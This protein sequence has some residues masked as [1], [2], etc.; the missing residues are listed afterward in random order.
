MKKVGFK[1]S[2]VA[3]LVLLSSKGYALPY[4]TQHLE[5]I[6]VT[7][8]LKT[9][10]KKQM[11][12][13]N[14]ANYK[15]NLSD[16]SSMLPYQK[17]K[18]D[19]SA[20]PNNDLE[21]LIN[22]T[23]GLDTIGAPKPITQN[24]QVNGLDVSTGRSIFAINGVSQASFLNTSGHGNS[25]ILN[26]P[27]PFLLHSMSV[28]QSGSNLSF[29]SGDMGGVIDTETLTAKSL[30][31]NKEV[32][33]KLYLGFDFNND[34]FT[35]GIATGIQNDQF[36]FLIAGIG[37]QNN[38]Y[39]DGN[40][41]MVKDSEAHQFQGL[42]NFNWDINDYQ[43]LNLSYLNINNDTNSKI[44]PNDEHDYAPTILKL[45]TQQ[46]N[47]K[48]NLNPDNQYVNLKLNLF[49]LK[50]RLNQQTPSYSLIP[51]FPTIPAVNDK[52]TGTK[53]GFKIQN[54]TNLYKQNITYGLDYQYT[55][56]NTNSPRS[57]KT[58]KSNQNQFGIFIKDQIHLTKIW[59]ITPG[60][61]FDDYT[62]KGFDIP[63]EQNIKS[64]QTDKDSK[65]S[66]SISTKLQLTDSLS[67]YLA[68]TEGFRAP[69]F[70]EQFAYGSHAGGIPAIFAPNFSLKPEESANKEFGFDYKKVL[71]NDDLLTAHISIFQNDI[72]NFINSQTIGHT[73]PEPFIPFEIDQYQN[74]DKVRIKGVNINTSYKNEYFIFYTSYTYNR[75][76]NTDNG[77]LI[78]NMPLSKGYS[79][80]S[81]PVKSMDTTFIFSSNYAARQTYSTESNDG[82]IKTQVN[83]GYA[84]YNANVSYQPHSIKDLTL[85]AGINNITNKAYRT[86][87][88]SDFF[89][90]GRNV[91][92]SMNY[93]F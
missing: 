75:G 38:N 90:M 50:N 56:Y 67:T 58:P 9:K 91:F 51:G 27:S 73:P 8:Q 39:K 37:N 3:I 28:Y 31:K 42:I 70:F 60:L 17:Y 20:T 65:L 47:L 41:Q 55:K 10:Q 21:N 86:N 52:N 22:L 7:G 29:G 72:H 71:P 77:Q 45:N 2:S 62:N 89:E 18:I 6:E 30:L 82:S 44:F 68:Y 53:Q 84:I 69:N 59:S 16:S 26:T 14:F 43:S 49:Y 85:N 93:N 92:L 48:Y 23:P 63:N 15:T 64:N 88:D 79:S 25:T 74:I 32:G 24:I 33:G 81:I 80:I 66:K 4:N 13:S 1:L 54:T 5:S 34:K 40:N 76:I 61:R 57:S 83:P 46:Y 35:Q 19:V 11:Q 36:G 12:S 78:D 87:Y